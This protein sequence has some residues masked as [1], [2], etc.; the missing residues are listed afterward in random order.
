MGTRVW[1]L[2]IFSFT[3][4]NPDRSP[5]RPSQQRSQ[6]PTWHTQRENGHCKDVVMRWDPASLEWGSSRRHL[7]TCECTSRLPRQLITGVSDSRINT[8]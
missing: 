5:W 2:C 8:S 3:L 6:W 7:P 1:G 4:W